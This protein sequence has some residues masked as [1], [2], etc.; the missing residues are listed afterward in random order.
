MPPYSETGT[1]YELP[2]DNVPSVEQYQIRAMNEDDL[3]AV[4]KIEQD[5]W[6]D[7][8]WYS[9]DFYDALCDPSVNCWILEDTTMSQSIV[10]YGLQRECQSTSHISN[11][12]LH[13]DQCG[14]GLGGLLLRHMIDHANR[15]CATGVALEVHITNSRAYNLY[16]KHG[17]AIVAFLDCYYADNADA[18]RMEL[19]F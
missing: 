19:L 6:R 5:T 12:T 3:E 1:G 10:G 11:L 8:A 4:C 7:N 16:V 18:Y 14:R 15:D 17:F 2:A 13:P 9:E